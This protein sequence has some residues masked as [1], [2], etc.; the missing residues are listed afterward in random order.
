MTFEMWEALPGI[1]GAIDADD[2]IKVLIVRGTGP[3]F[4]AGAD[5]SEFDQRRDTAEAGDAYGHSV[6][7]AAHALTSM[8]KPSV[9][10]IQGSCMG[11]GCELA[12]SCDLRFA[13]TTA[14]FSIPPAKTGSRLR[15]HVHPPA[16]HSRRT[17]VR[18]VSA[19]LGEHHRR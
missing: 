10:V 13:D 12:L 17:V 1:V 3:H 4:C 15:V 7:L 8:R 9:A 16:R 5:V 6:E 11:G 19:L 18:Q 14:R 2:A